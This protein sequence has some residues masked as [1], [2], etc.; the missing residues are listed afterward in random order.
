MTKVLIEENNYSIQR[1]EEKCC[2]CG[3]CF[4]TCQ[5]LNDILKNDCLNCGQCI[6][7]CP[8]GAL[9][10]KYNYKEV[11]ANIND[12]E[13]I[14]VVSI[15]PAVR[16]AIGDFFGYQPGEFLETKLV[17]ALK[18]LGFDYVF[19]ITSGADLTIMEE[20]TELIKRLE[21]KENLPL[22][23]SCCPSWVLNM[24]KYHKNDLKL[25]STCKSPIGMQGAIIKNYWKEEKN[26]NSSDIVTATIAPCVSKK[27]EIKNDIN[28][29]YILTTSELALML[30]EQEINL[31][32][33]KESNFDPILGK[34]SGAGLIFGTSGGVTEAVLRCAYYLINKEEP[35]KDFLTI[36]SLRDTDF[37][38]EI[39]VDLKKF[40]IKVAVLNG[41]KNVNQIFND[42]KNYHF[43]EVMA[44]IGGCSGGGGQ[45]LVP[46]HSQETYVQKRRESLYQND[47]ICPLKNSYE[48]KNIT[49]IHEKDINEKEKLFHLNHF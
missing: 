5:K 11:M 25:L 28:N 26:L 32:A 46:Q 35:P 38:R 36:N 2:D 49:K 10:P 29:D 14:V 16:V 37:L 43:V 30:K 6:L 40:K 34:G 23:T 42:L 33:V 1:I 15:A 39:E 22:F 48:N 12:E 44:C 8:M 41:I 18:K 21:T 45:S 20:A 3:V 31:T 7:T 47:L 27:T 13:K 17:G 4:N 24:K 9:A 19:D